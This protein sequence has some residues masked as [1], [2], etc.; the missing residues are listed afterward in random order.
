MTKEQAIKEFLNSSEGTFKDKQKVAKSLGVELSPPTLQK[1]LTGSRIERNH[2]NSKKSNAAGKDY[3]VIPSLYLSD[4]SST[5]EVWCRIEAAR[6]VG[7][8]LIRLANEASE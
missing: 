3:A 4:K 2:S 7:E 1:Q 6:E 8:A 5:R